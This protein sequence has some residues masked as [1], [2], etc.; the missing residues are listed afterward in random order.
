MLDYLQPILLVLASILMLGL[1]VQVL[2]VA[3]EEFYFNLREIIQ[4]WRDSRND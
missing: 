2:M 1:A 3:C 4:E